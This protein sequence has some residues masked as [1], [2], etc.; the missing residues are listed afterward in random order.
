MFASSRRED[1]RCVQMGH[2]N[3]DLLQ[4]AARSFIGSKICYGVPAN[5]PEME[6]KIWL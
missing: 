4:G 3:Y 5:T 1:L 6:Q 2:A